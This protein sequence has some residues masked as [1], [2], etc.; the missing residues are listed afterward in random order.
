MK[1]KINKP[2]NLFGLTDSVIILKEK[3]L[4]SLLIVV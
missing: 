3:G 1:L 2:Y 4:A